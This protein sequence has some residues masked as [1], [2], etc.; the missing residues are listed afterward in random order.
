M[1]QINITQAFFDCFRYSV[2]LVFCLR[3]SGI[4]KVYH[5]LNDYR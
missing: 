5:M 3:Q 2:S 4:Q 1:N